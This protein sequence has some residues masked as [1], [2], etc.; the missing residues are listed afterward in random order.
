M[1]FIRITFLL[2]TAL[3]LAK[4]GTAQSNTDWI[5]SPEYSYSWKT[6]DRMAYSAKVSMFNSVENIDNRS[7]IQNIEPQLSFAYG[8]TPRTKIGGGY[9]YRWSSPLLD[10]YQYEH[11]FLQQVGFINFIGD[12]RIA[13]RL[14]TE[15][16]I[17]SSSY[18][19]RVRYRISYDF[20]L[21]GDRLDPGERYLIFSNEMMSAFNADEA[22]AENRFSAGMG[23]F[24]NRQQKFE[25]GVQYRTQ[26]IF[27][28]DGISHLFLVSTS[29]YMNR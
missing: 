8:L 3:F 7:F 13:H 12:R 15:Q 21:E 18:Q 17:R 20:P 9:Y 26:D 22:D 4:S 6:S 28:G 5:W 14:R 23:W 11:R 2:L 10:G 19:N 29:F 16:R 24:F 1:S 25:L 27:S